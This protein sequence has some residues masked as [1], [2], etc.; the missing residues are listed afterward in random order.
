MGNTEPE[1]PATPASNLEPA[2]DG[3]AVLEPSS[4]PAAQSEV[5]AAPAEPAAGSD[6]PSGPAAKDG[7]VVGATVSAA[8]SET[9]T[10]PP[11]RRRLS[12]AQCIAILT[13]SYI[14]AKLDD[15]E[16]RALFRAVHALAR[17][18]AQKE[19]NERSRA[20]RKVK[21]VPA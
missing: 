3:A 6:L 2:N 12:N 16:K 1:T 17:R 14:V 13:G 8:G 20:A 9:S 19:R 4:A 15:T 5:A 10:P 21:E 11:A 7:S 18:V